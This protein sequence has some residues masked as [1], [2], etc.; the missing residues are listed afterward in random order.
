MSLFL[1]ALHANESLGHQA[2]FPLSLSYPTALETE[3]KS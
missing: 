3:Q 1:V 2:N